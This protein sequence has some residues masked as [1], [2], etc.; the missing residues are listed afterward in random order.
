MRIQSKTLIAISMVVAA[1]SSLV[2]C[3]QPA[4]P[5]KVLTPYD[6]G[7]NE[8]VSQTEDR[9]KNSPLT[10]QLERERIYRAAMEIEVNKLEEC[11][12]Y[13]NVCPDSVIAKGLSARKAGFTSG[14]V[15]IAGPI[16]ALKI[17]VLTCLALSI[18]SVVWILILFLL[19][20]AYAF[21][22]DV[23]ALYK[24]RE[25]L[26]RAQH[27]EV[28]STLRI[29]QTE[30]YSQTKSIDKELQAKESLLSDFENIKRKE[31][32]TLEAAISTASKQLAPLQSSLATKTKALKDIRSLIAKAITRLN[33]LI[34]TQSLTQQLKDPE[35]KSLLIKIAAST[36]LPNSDDSSKTLADVAPPHFPTNSIKEIL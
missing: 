30:L 5:P 29:N 19:G 21:F 13:I 9:F 20:P 23:E 8:G 36:D 33:T 34:Q 27:D 24:N 10:L 15:S 25:K 12:A 6:Q 32:L 26:I 11:E 3:D 16:L 4:H 14:K 35:T 2:G 22:S 18:L 28:I 1:T 17:F 7:F 31:W